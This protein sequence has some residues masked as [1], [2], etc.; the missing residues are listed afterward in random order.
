MSD[1]IEKS[2]TRAEFSWLSLFQLVLSS[3][4]FIV[5]GFLSLFFALI[6]IG[7][8]ANQIPGMPDPTSTFLYV[9]GLAFG[10][11]LLLPSAGYALLRLSG[12]ERL[13]DWRISSSRW[14]LI[15][16]GLLVFLLPLVLLAGN[17][18]TAHGRIAWFALPPLHILA[19]VIPIFWLLVVGLNGLSP[20]SGQRSWGLLGAGLALGPVLILTLELALLAGFL[21]VAV[22]FIARQPELSDE[23]TNLAQR[24]RFAPR[25]PDVLARIL[26]PYILHPATVT[27][28]FAY[29]ALFVPLIEEVIKP[30][31]VW[32]LASRKLSPVD[33]FVAGLLSGA[34]YA[35]FE[36][37]FLSSSGS[38]WMSLVLARV[39]TGAVHMFTAS[40]VGWGLASAWGGGRY[41]RLGLSF[42]CAV[43]VH[44][45]WNGLT[46]L[47]AGLELF[48]GQTLI[49]LDRL[50]NLFSIG[51]GSLAFLCV[52]MIW[53]FNR[54]L[55]RAIIA[56][57]PQ[58]AL[59]DAARLSDRETETDEV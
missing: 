23:L 20:G 42:A 16:S 39:G 59:P 38:Q 41:L 26:Q 30:I 8:I 18:V 33:G 53:L 5:L 4:A 21:V 2:Q 50:G 55:K 45:L 34:G 7:Q 46:L 3:L 24:L 58:A 28:I 52:L 19:V 11:F 29:I 48:S 40:L 1:S 13:R 14:L 32:F 12:R 44:G 57:L 15:A 36:N 6:G 56:P 31:G 17:L 10:S 49:P 22:L 37:L 51:L 35:L 27:G 9:G 43:L 25:T 54:L 47:T